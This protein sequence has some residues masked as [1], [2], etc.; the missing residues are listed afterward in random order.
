MKNA[1]ETITLL[2]RDSNPQE[3]LLQIEQLNIVNHCDRQGRTLLINAAFY[4]CYEIA[5]YLIC[6]GANVNAVDKQGISALHAAVQENNREIAALLL[7]NGADVNLKNRF[8]NT[9]LWMAR[10]TA[11]DELFILLLE[12]GANPSITNNY[13]VSVVDGFVA[14]P[15][16]YSLITRYIK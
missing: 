15:D 6:H 12:N 14:F 9:P 2:M 1:V 8:G 3:I 16:K 13:G 4:G 11:P 10:P 5:D 7:R